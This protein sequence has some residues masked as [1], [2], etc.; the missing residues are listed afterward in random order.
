MATDL[1]SICPRC[2]GADIAVARDGVGTRQCKA[3]GLT[4]VPDKWLALHQQKQD[5]PDAVI[6]S[7]PS[8]EEHAARLRDE[9]EAKH[10][11]IRSVIEPLV[12]A[13]LRNARSFTLDLTA[14]H[15]EYGAMLGNVLEDIVT[16]LKAKNW[17]AEW[18]YET[19]RNET[20]V[21]L[22]VAGGA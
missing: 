7:F 9:T 20:E 12:H 6:S 10:N 4:A 8:F 19:H 3:C 5:T 22:K 13:E 2:E 17:N 16:E 21:K 18:S 11:K 15:K 1:Y 14:Q